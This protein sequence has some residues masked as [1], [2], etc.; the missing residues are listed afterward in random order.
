MTGATTNSAHTSIVVQ[1]VFS[2]LGIVISWGLAIFLW[3]V[4]FI[5]TSYLRLPDSTQVS[6]L[7]FATV[8]VALGACFIPSMLHSWREMRGNPT[9]P[10]KIQSGKIILGLVIAWPFVIYAGMKLPQNTT[11][12][13]ILFPWIHV[14]AV[15]IPI[16]ALI[17]LAT[18]QLSTTSHRRNAGLLASGL[19]LGTTGSILL[20]MVS[21]LSAFMVLIL[22]VAI[23][24]DLANS[25]N[26]LKDLFS[27]G[28]QNT[29]DIQALAE[30]LLA[31]PGAITFILLFVSFITPL[32]EEAFKPI[33][34][35]FFKNR[36]LT[37]EDG[38]IGGILSGAG[39]ALFETMFSGFQNDPL[40]WLT[41]IV[42]RVGADALHMLASGLV[43]YSLVQSWQEENFRPLGKGY[44]LAVLLHGTWNCLA[45]LYS[46][47]DFIPSS[48]WIHGFQ[49]AGPYALAILAVLILVA[50]GVFNRR[51]SHTSSAAATGEVL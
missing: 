9:S 13:D 15:L 40:S 18:H 32:I 11:S 28:M 46:I 22:F 16:L 41:I 37:P 5:Q 34:L 44:L 24:P 1:F 6:P 17:W 35:L 8:L 30:T 25:I 20:E 19:T 48:S 27:S 31:S 50:L 12:H 43:G 49:A 7:F 42:L 36:G 45:M 47:S 3:F 2:I 39:F 23:K 29:T 10:G 33:G 14:A 51:L 26:Q 38:F 4:G 21:L